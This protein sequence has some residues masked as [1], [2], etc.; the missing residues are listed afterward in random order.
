MLEIVI[1]LL[2]VLRMKVKESKAGKFL[3]ILQNASDLPIEF[4]YLEWYPETCGPHLA[5]L[6]GAA[7]SLSYLW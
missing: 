7:C 6:C 5:G 3:S 1:D 2:E 4:F